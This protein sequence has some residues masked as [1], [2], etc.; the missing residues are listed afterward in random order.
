MSS[1][2]PGADATQYA[3]EIVNLVLIVDELQ[4]KMCFV[5]SCACVRVGCAGVLLYTHVYIYNINLI[6][7]DATLLLSLHNTF[8]R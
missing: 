1:D 8:P 6:H 7:A 5:E 2:H 3:N 4:V